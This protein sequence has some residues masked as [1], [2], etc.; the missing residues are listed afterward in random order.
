MPQ[1]EAICPLGTQ[2]SPCH[3][4]AC[5][6]SQS[7]LHQASRGIYRQLTPSLLPLGKGC[8]AVRVWRWGEGASP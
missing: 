3:R 4:S 6:W 8:W 7:P 1:G 5:G 2:R